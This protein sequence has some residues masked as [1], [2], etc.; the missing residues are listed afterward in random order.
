M[1]RTNAPGRSSAHSTATRVPTPRPSAHTRASP[2][3]RPSG[4][5]QP[6][7]VLNS[8]NACGAPIR[9]SDV[10]PLTMWIADETAGDIDDLAA[11]RD[12]D[13]QVGVHHFQPVVRLPQVNVRDARR[14]DRCIGSTRRSPRGRSPSA[15]SRRRVSGEVIA[16]DLKRLAAVGPV[17]NVPDRAAD[18]AS[19]NRNRCAW[20]L[21][22][23]LTG[24]RN[25]PTT[26]GR[27]S[28][29]SQRVRSAKPGERR[30]LKPAAPASSSR[31]A[32]RANRVEDR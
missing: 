17:R 23:L 7:S 26:T 31:E 1:H 3:R 18:T 21:P 15:P 22:V 10:S 24:I 28:S 25:G 13:A 20:L 8:E 27:G 29:N 32:G 19:A 5:R 9:N 30:W 12:V 11:R 6:R 16:R 4:E 2:A 14:V